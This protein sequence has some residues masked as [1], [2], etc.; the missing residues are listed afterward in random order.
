MS[1]PRVETI[2]PS[3][4]WISQSLLNE[5]IWQDHPDN[6]Q[7]N[8]GIE[9]LNT[10]NSRFYSLFS[11][12][13]STPKPLLDFQPSGGEPDHVIDIENRLDDTNLASTNTTEEDQSFD[14]WPNI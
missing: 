14:E 7:Q 10:Q 9:S 8:G 11:K 2:V 4:D 13:T 1:P 5:T 6:V 12:G 3:Q